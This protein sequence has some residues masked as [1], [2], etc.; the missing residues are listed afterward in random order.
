MESTSYW[1]GLGR[2]AALCTVLS[3]FV[4][5]W[6]LWE[7]TND[8]ELD[9]ANNAVR[10][11]LSSSDLIEVAN[12]I[13]EAT[14]EGTDYTKADENEPLQRDINNY[15]NAL[16]SIATGVN[17]GFYNEELVCHH[18]QHIIY[19][20]AKAHLFGESGRLPSG[21]QW[22]TDQALF[23]S[24]GYFPELRKLFKHWFPSGSLSNCPL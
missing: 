20:Q 1:R 11:F 8:A 14:A 16:E 5:A 23:S 15:L 3:L 19:K 17:M 2:L 12:R 18:L 13:S 6:Q 9:R 7:Q 4:A 24:D 21:H 10:H 22:K